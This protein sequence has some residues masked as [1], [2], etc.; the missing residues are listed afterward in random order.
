MN[1]NQNKSNDLC[2]AGKLLEAR[3]NASTDNL[4][5]AT[6]SLQKICKEISET[7]RQLS[8][9]AI[10]DLGR[11]EVLEK[12]RDCKS[13]K[14]NDIEGNM[15]ELEVT[16]ATHLGEHVATKRQEGVEG[17]KWGILSGGGIAGLIEI[18]RQV[19]TKLGE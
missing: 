19:L 15:Q 12:S 8:D 10:R 11:I 13:K 4:L 6:A 18:G 9:Y 14:I 5:R 3:L 2:P 17:R 1:G 7:M 16:V